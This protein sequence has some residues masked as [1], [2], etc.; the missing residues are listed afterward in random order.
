MTRRILSDRLFRLSSQVRSAPSTILAWLAAAPERAGLAIGDAIQA[1]ATAVRG[2]GCTDDPECCRG[3]STTN[4][5]HGDW[6]LCDCHDANTTAQ[7]AEHA[8]N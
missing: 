5:K 3:A 1:L 2:C 8:E 6:C 7:A 4:P